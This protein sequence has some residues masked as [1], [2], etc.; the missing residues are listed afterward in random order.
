MT[1]YHAAIWIDHREAH[2][3]DIGPEDFERRT[4]RSHGEPHQHHK[5]GSVGSGHAKADEAFFHAAAQAVAGAREVYVCG[6]GSA[7]AELIHHMESHDPAIAKT[8]VAVEAMDHPTD[9][10]VVAAARK[11]FKAFD[12]TTPQI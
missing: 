4:V 9:R 2:V 1:H 10:Q 6:P 11:F 3:F 7:K 5:A 8:V 12:R